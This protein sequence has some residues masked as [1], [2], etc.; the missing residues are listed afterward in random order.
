VEGRPLRVLLAGLVGCLALG[1][2]VLRLRDGRADA[3]VMAAYLATYLL[4]PFYDQM[5]RFLFPALPVLVLYAFHAAAEAARRL[6][7]PAAFGQALTGFLAASLSLPALAFVHQRADAPL[8]YPE[9]TDWYR[10]PDLREA[11]A[12]SDV[13]LGLLEDMRTIAALTRPGDRVAW[14]KPAYI[15]LLA[16]REGIRSPSASL[17]SAAYRRAL[18]ASGADYVFLSVYHPRDTLS[19]AAW[20]TGVRALY[21]KARLVHL[22]TRRDSTLVASMLFQVK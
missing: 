17:D 10:T 7:R 14:V 22:G 19:D 15:A 4:W 1:G 9:M 18:R 5:G 6:G 21:G 3:W 16:G 20:Q 13:H 12:R 8:P 11:K 2:L